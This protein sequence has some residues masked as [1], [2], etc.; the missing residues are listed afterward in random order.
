MSR[1]VDKPQ[2][3][4]AERDDLV[5]LQETLRLDNIML[6]YARAKNLLNPRLYPCHPGFIA[7]M[8]LGKQAVFFLNLVT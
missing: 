2:R 1:S 7:M 3:M 8:Y 6:E 5:I 4:V